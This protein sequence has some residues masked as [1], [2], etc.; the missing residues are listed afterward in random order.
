MLIHVGWNTE[1]MDLVGM[2]FLFLQWN[3]DGLCM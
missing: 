2:Y 1:S 3:K